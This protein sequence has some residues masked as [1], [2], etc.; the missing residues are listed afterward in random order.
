[1]QR[2]T[3]VGLEVAITEL[4]IRMT[5]PATSQN[6]QSQATQYAQV[7]RACVAVPRCVGIVSTMLRLHIRDEI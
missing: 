6:L 3:A 2:F 5:L 4:D 1:M 7:V